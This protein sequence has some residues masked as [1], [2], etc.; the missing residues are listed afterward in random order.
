MLY[1][2]L[3]DLWGLGGSCLCIGTGKSEC[4]KRENDEGKDA[5]HDK[6]FLADRAESIEIMGKSQN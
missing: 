4:R 5:Y 1:Y 2:I 6:T 3:L